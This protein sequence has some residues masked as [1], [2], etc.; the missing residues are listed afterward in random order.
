M[1]AA[2]AAR[3]LR[4]TIDPSDAAMWRQAGELRRGMFD[5][6]VL[7][8]GKRLVAKHK[9]AA[10]P[11]CNHPGISRRH[12]GHAVVATLRL[13]RRLERPEIRRAQIDRALKTRNQ[14]GSALDTDHKHTLIRRYRHVVSLQ[15]QRPV[16]SQP[17]GESGFA[18]DE[19]KVPFALVPI[20]GTTGARVE[21]DA[22]AIPDIKPALLARTR[23]M[24]D[25]NLAERR[26]KSEFR[27][28]DSN[29]SYRSCKRTSLQDLPAGQMQGPR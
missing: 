18:S 16:G 6:Q 15:D 10:A 27:T 7:H 14:D 25:Q 11:S 12:R 21:I 4:A 3:K 24:V 23:A 8:R 5:E 26:E 28:E 19:A 9:L 1:A 29:T 20:D 13:L 22:D 2:E 17:Y